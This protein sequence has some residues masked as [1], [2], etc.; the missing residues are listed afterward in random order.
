MA[1]A[2]DVINL[3][4]RYRGVKEDPANS[5]HQ[6]FGVWYGIDRQPW[7]AMFASFILYTCGMRFPGATTAKGWSFCPSIAAWAQKRGLLSTT[8]VVGALALFSNGTRFHHV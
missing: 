8:P 1:T 4:R 3:A 2:Q 6:R 7:C 5:N